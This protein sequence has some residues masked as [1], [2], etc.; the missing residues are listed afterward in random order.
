MNDIKDLALNE[1]GDVILYNNDIEMIFDN[2]VLAQEARQIIGTS[3]GE[4]FLNKNQGI[5]RKKILVKNPNMDMIKDE[6][7][8]ALKTLDD[9]FYIDTFEYE[10]ID[11]NMTIKFKAINETGKEISTNYKYEL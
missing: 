2:E 10:T 6:I 11:R 1:Y 3:K 5:D 8:Q 4:W 7:L 9:T